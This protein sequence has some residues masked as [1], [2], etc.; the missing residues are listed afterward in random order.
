MTENYDTNLDP[1]L[2]ADAD[3]T[4]QSA[5]LPEFVPAE[6]TAEEAFVAAANAIPAVGGP[7]VVDPYAMYNGTENRVPPTAT[8]VNSPP[9]PPAAPYGYPAAAYGTR[10]PFDGFAI[11]ALV[12]AVGGFFLIPVIG[13]IL[14]VIFGIIALQRLRLQ[15][16]RGKEMAIAGIIVGALGILLTIAGIVLLFAIVNNPTSNIIFDAPIARI[17]GP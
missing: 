13:S 7:V 2:G 6:S 17:I 15:G 3:L 8:A 4:P 5:P 11:A 16:T 9:P 12:C 10:A 1:N 14:G